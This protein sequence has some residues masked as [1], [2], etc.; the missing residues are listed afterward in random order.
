MNDALPSVSAAIDS[1]S[2]VVLGQDRALKLM[3]C[4]LLARGHALLVGVPG[5]AKTLLSRTLARTVDCRFRRIQFT[6]D[7]MPSDILGTH[8]F[9]PSAQT[10]VVQK[11][12]IFTDVL[13][14]DEINRTPPKTQAALLEAMEERAATLDGDRHAI[15]DV[16][17]VFAT[18]NPLEFEGTY[19]LPEAQLDRFM[20][21]ITVPY[22]SVDAEREVLRRY[23][24]GA[25][26]HRAAEEAVTPV[27]DREA[28]LAMLEVVH[29]VHVED[30]VLDYV[31]RLVLATR[32][33]EPVE[34]GAGTRAGLH[35]LLAS[36]AWAL[37]E[38]RDFVTPDDIKE[39]AAPVCAH[40]IVLHPDAQVDG[41]RPEQVLADLLRRVEVPR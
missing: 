25:N 1:V 30:R 35:L 5:T 29:R 15:S 4:C 36:R 40:R 6:P 20:M 23:S 24:S 10:F 28:L 18:Q 8:V 38:G 16:F 13:L 3:L 7:L 34:L 37:I 39:L 12:P 11:G 21:S 41:L 27:F 33:A 31:H 14:A 26:A 17:T 19:P 2:S 9:D 22:P 32:S